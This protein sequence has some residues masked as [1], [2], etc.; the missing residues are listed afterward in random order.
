MS[1]FAV[2]SLVLIMLTLAAI[3]SA[4]VLLV[5]TRSA[6]NGIPS[7]VAAAMG[8]VLGD[9]VFVALAILGMSMLAET[10]GAFFVP[11]KYMCGAYLIWAGIQLLRTTS[12][13][14]VEQSPPAASMVGS[15][16][17]GLFLT[18]GDA[19]A[20]LFYAS[21]FPAFI[22]L[23]SLSTAEVVWIVAVT[24]VAV[25]SVKIAYAFAARALVARFKHRKEMRFL[26][27][28]AGGMTVGIGAYMMAR[29]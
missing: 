8:I 15:F 11:L 10:M 28:A 21:L 22:D 12:T 16:L 20:I 9:L 23:A 24:I 29:N 26:T 6:V 4:S 3:P 17:A 13:S 27:K 25:G 19:K 14:A 2:A 5:V 18:L 7:G 1:L